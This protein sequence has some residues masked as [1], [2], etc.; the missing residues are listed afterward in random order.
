MPQKNCWKDSG[1]RSELQGSWRPSTATICSCNS[2][3]RVDAYLGLSDFE[4]MLPHLKNYLASHA[5]Y[6]TNRYELPAE[7]HAEIA[8]RWGVIDHYGYVR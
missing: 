5:G 8:R 7:T 2:W 3:T 1:I 6:E 4:R